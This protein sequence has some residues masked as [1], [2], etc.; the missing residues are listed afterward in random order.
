MKKFSVLN[1]SSSV[2]PAFRQRMVLVFFALA[3]SLSCVCKVSAQEKGYE[4]GDVVADFS[5]KNVDGKAVSMEGFSDAKGYIIVFTCNTCP[6]AKAY[7]A[8]IKELDKAYKAKGYPVIAI[9]PNDPEVQGE[10][11]EAMQKRAKDQGYTY[12]YLMDP[13]HRVTKLF[14]ATRTPH[15][16]VVEK[17]SEGNVLQYIGA[18]DNS[19]EGEPSNLFV[20]TAV[21]DLLAGNKPT[22]N[23]TKAVGCTIKWRKSI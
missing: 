3:V 22:T 4:I 19:T 18:I 12:P 10:A 13:E 20:Q 6:V 11:F 9:N 2:L 14:G 15:V 8:R 16:F 21:D 5:L 1:L 7:E 17:T 23:F